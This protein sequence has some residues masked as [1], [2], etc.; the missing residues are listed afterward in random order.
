MDY[1][2]ILA[3]ASKKYNIPIRDKE[4]V[5]APIQSEEG[6]NYFAAMSAGINCAL[7]NRQ[8]IAHLART[9]FEKVFPEAKVE[10]LYDISHNTC[11]IEEHEVNGEKRKLYIHRKG[12]TRAFGPGRKELPKDYMKAGQPVL[13]G[14][15]MGTYSYILAGTEHGTSKTFGSACHGGGRRMSRKK[16]KHKWFGEKVIQ[17]LAKKGIIV[18]AHSYAGVAEEAPGAYKD[19]REVVDSVHNAGLAVKVVRTR[20][21]GTIKG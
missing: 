8:V 11:K 17:D 21:I 9:A 3:Q 4:L 1:L 5:C 10:T 6:R 13:I 18:K 2:Q 14:G 7:A 16:A 12:A 19:V 15:S 20:P